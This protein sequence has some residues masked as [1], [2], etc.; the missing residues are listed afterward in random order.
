MPAEAP[1]ADRPGG[2]SGRRSLRRWWWLGLLAI[3]LFGVYGLRLFLQP[4]RMGALIVAQ[5][6]QAT[7]LRF[8]LDAPARLGL[9]PRLHL[10]LVGARISD[11]THPAPL[12][13]AERIELALP[14][15][16]LWSTPSQIGRIDLQSPDIDLP[17]LLDWLSPPIDAG[18]PEPLRLPAFATEAHLEN[19]R[20]RGDGFELSG[21]DALLSPLRDGESATL[22]VEGYTSGK[23]GEDEPREFVVELT[24]VPRERADG[25]Q[26]DDFA[27]T[28]RSATAEPVALTVT[29]DLGLQ[30]P[31]RLRADFLIAMSDPLPLPIELPPQLQQW[32]GEPTRLG[33]DGPSDL[34]GELRLRSAT[35][36]LTVDL[37]TRP[38]ALLDWVATGAS[39]GLPPVGGRMAVP[40][41]EQSGVRVSGLRIEIGEDP[42]A[43]PAAAPADAGATK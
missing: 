17:L 31:A 40:D 18:P 43:R 22:R 14:L 28:V 23:T 15:S 5:A 30:L 1:A 36:P 25:L 21:V 12:L 8:D 35:E 37:V 39:A 7:G 3:A 13:A 34:S 26:I 19:G 10:Q 20:L 27:L 29:G 9:W 42:E 16:V 2:R 32:L 4:E 33:Y 6:E 41:F 11:P 38:R 24:A